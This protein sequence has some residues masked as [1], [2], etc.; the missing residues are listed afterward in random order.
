MLRVSASRHPHGALH[1]D[2][3]LPIEGVGDDE[4]CRSDTR[5]YLYIIK[6]EFICATNE[7]FNF[8]KC[9]NL[10]ISKFLFME[11]LTTSSIKCD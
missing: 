6:G 8:K 9:T 3:K 2:L 10:T 7:K 11:F 1:Q 4:A 5:L